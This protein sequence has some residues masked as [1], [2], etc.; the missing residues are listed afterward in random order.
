MYKMNYLRSANEDINEVW[1][2]LTKYN[3]KFIFCQGST[4]LV[5]ERCH[6]LSGDTKVVDSS[7]VCL[8]R[9]GTQSDDL[10][11]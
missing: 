7:I 9:T 8:V 6:I 5:A 4:I 11:V 1:N 2:I 10:Q 3:M